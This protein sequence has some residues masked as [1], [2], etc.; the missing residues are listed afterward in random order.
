MRTGLPRPAAAVW[1]PTATVLVACMLGGCPGRGR[2][3]AQPAVELIPIVE[4]LTDERYGPDAG[5]RLD[6]VLAGQKAEDCR[7]TETVA[8]S[9]AGYFLALR[10]SSRA[11]DEQVLAQTV[12][13]R[14]H[15]GGP[16]G[17][18]TERLHSL[19]AF[20]L[21]DEGK[22]RAPV[23]LTLRADLGRRRRAGHVHFL[24]TLHVALQRGR[25]RHMVPGRDHQRIVRTTE[26]KKLAGVHMLVARHGKPTSVLL[27][28]GVDLQSNET[29]LRLT[30]PGLDV[31]LSN[32]RPAPEPTTWP[33]TRPAPATQPG[34][35]AA[36]APNGKP[37]NGQ[38]DAA[39]G[40]REGENVRR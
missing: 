29:V 5:K 14:R 15:R 36:P 2:A 1:V 8:L 13:V 6:R 38:G 20:R 37:G 39:V 27:R 22:T 9:P 4:L 31:R 18:H 34:G 19:E 26:E 35:P 10:V 28:W 23:P 11:G 25:Y 3:P 21:D 7:R 33:A 40:R 12:R 16:R 17:D 30:G 32:R 24:Q